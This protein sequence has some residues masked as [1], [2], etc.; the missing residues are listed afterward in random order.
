MLIEHI[1]TCSMCQEKSTVR[2]VTFFSQQ[3]SQLATH[4]MPHSLCTYAKLSANCLDCV[5][6][7]TTSSVLNAQE[8]NSR[9]SD[10]AA[11][12]VF[13]LRGN[14]FKSECAKQ[15]VGVNALVRM[16]VHS[17]VG[18]FTGCYVLASYRCLVVKCLPV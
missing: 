7:K 6:E 1:Y 2:P 11:S 4:S 15:L 17:G 8:G 12:E 14:R 18:A 16:W 5:A 3:P 9:T 10:E 13:E